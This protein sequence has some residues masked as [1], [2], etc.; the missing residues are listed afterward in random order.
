MSP[1][2]CRQSLQRLMRRQSR[3]IDDATEYLDEIKQAFVDNRLKGMQDLLAAPRFDLT[4]I[5]TLEQERHRLL[6]DYGYD[7]DERG[8]QLCIEWCDDAGRETSALYLELIDKLK[9]LQKAI[10]VNGLLIRKGRDRVQRS[11]GVLTGIAVG[12]CKTYS[13]DGQTVDTARR[14]N[15]AIA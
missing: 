7:R 9:T 4:E 15:I 3:C 11:I 13:S 10:Q 8:F 5:E 12:D 6:A 2:D 1:A 14:R